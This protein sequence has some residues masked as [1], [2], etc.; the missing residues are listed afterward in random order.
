MPLAILWELELILK[1]IW[2]H[3]RPLNRQSI[4]PR[5][6]KMHYKATMTKTIRC[7]PKHRC[8]NQ[9]DGRA[10]PCP[11]WRGPSATTEETD[12]RRTG[13]R[14]SPREAVLVKLEH[15]E[16]GPLSHTT[17][18]T[19]LTWSWAGKRHPAASDPERRRQSVANRL[20]PS[21]RRDWSRSLKG[22]AHSRTRSQTLT[23]APQSRG[24][25]SRDTGDE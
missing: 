18:K 2:K 1:F 7:R 11:R 19:K 5:D 23:G 8:T 13:Q 16:T 9:Q 22:P 3:M 12:M 20:C 17:H 14:W 4:E 10:R 6:I 15:N 21:A 24:V 25:S